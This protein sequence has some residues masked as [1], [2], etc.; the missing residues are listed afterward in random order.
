MIVQRTFDRRTP[1][2]LVAMKAWGAPA[3]P[4][5][6][7]EEGVNATVITVTATAIALRIDGT[8]SMAASRH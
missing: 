3:A 7:A 6:N 1:Q 2:V 8:T 5:T 4:D